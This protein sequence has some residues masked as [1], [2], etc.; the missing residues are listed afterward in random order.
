MDTALLRELR[1]P[2]CGGAFSA[3]MIEHVAGTPVYGVLTCACGQYPVLDGIPILKKGVI[4]PASQTADHVIALLQAGQYHEALLAMIVPPTPAPVSRQYWPSG[5]GLW[6]LHHLAQ[7]WTARTWR[8]QCAAL[9]REHR[10]QMTACD[11]F[12]LYFRQSK[13]AM[14][15]YDLTGCEFCNYS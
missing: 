7:Q 8:Q 12:D 5:L 13:K 11:L 1:C 4:G 2:F 9:L 14:N 10:E 6:R 3:S 15:A